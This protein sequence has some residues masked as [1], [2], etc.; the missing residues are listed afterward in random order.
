MEN[1]KPAAPA[2]IE[3]IP[4]NPPIESEAAVTPTDIAEE[5][6]VDALEEALHAEAIVCEERHEQLLTALEQQGQTLQT[7]IR[8]L[9]QTDSPALAQIQA[10][11]T[12]M[13]SQL[14]SLSESLRSS[15]QSP[16]PKTPSSESTP[17][18]PSS[19]ESTPEIPPESGLPAAP[20]KTAPK[21]RVRVV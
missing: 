15:S 14:T 8:N 7:E 9:A 2:A 6:E 20:E 12:E 5:E 18:T 21:R 1:P 17:R 16:H 4:A 10:Q 11:Q 3:V 13:L 19:A